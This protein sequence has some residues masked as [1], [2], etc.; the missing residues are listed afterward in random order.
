M[1]SRSSEGSAGGRAMGVAA[2]TPWLS[3]F[4]L[5][6]VIRGG[7]ACAALGWEEM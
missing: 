1:Y 3:T 6:G 4:L 7:V 2:I 5:N